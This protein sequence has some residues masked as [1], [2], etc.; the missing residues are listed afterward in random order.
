MKILMWNVRGLGKPARRRQ[1]REHIFQ[2]KVEVVGL[3]E[4]IK[5]DF[6]DQDLQKLAGGLQFIWAW[7]PA[8]G[9][10]GGILLGAKVDTLEVEAQCIREFSIQMDIRNR[11]T[12]FRCSVVAVY[13]P[14]HHNL[15]GIFLDELIEICTLRHLPMTLGGDFNLIRKESDKSSTL[16][17]HLLTSHFNDFIGNHCLREVTRVGSRYT[18]TNKQLSPVQA[19]LDRF[20]MTSDWEDKFPLCLAWGLTRVGS[21]HA[22]IILDFGEQGAPRPK[23]SKILLF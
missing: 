14:T 15:S 1:V 7:L 22:P 9:H 4:T 21:D 8:R 23:V 20:F 19:N 17:N 10:S 2:E 6:S 16:H 18:W 13:G 11:L 3:Q 12:N 5:G